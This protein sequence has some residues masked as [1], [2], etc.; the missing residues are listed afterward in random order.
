MS[1][2]GQPWKHKKKNTEKKK[3]KEKDKKSKSQAL[4]IREESRR[5]G[6]LAKGTL[7][8]KVSMMD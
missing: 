6:A 5:K 4:L 2:V 7:N 8:I 3:K 1:K